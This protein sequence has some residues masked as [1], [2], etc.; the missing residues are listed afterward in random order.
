MTIFLF[1]TVGP[2]STYYLIY[3]YHN[4][5]HMNPKTIIELNRFENSEPKVNIVNRENLYN[6]TY[7][8][9]GW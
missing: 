3:V 1:S 7:V 5:T 8:E 9:V 2:G 4:T 6:S